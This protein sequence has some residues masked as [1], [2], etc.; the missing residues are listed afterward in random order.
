MQ[1]CV[2]CPEKSGAQNCHAKV[3]FS[4]TIIAS[5]ENSDLSKVLMVVHGESPDLSKVVF[6]GIKVTSVERVQVYQMFGL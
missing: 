2:R 4:G 6:S 5:S 3:L 1:E